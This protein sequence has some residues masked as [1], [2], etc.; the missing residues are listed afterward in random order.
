M[1]TR[2]LE[3]RHGPQLLLRP[4]RFGGFETVRAVFARLGERSRLAPSNAPKP[5]LGE[6]EAR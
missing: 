2:V 1:L 3:L 6:Q 5:E 4:L